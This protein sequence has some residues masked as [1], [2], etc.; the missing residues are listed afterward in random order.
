MLCQR[1]GPPSAI[2]EEA[3]DYRYESM[4]LQHFECEQPS[5][6]L[7]RMVQRDDR[8]VHALSKGFV[9]KVHSAARV[10][11]PTLFE[12]FFLAVLVEGGHLEALKLWRLSGELP[13]PRM[14]LSRFPD[15]RLRC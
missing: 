15:Y 4:T 10:S 9:C 7:E 1:T 6:W 2:I 14:S 11:C 12:W 13:V 5:K 8:L 3:Q